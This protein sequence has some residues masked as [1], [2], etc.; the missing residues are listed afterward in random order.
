MTAGL[1][2]LRVALLALAVASC[3]SSSPLAISSRSLA[4]GE[5][6]AMALLGGSLARQSE[7]G[8]G[9]ARGDGQVL[10]VWW[11]GGWTAKTDGA[12]AALLDPSGKTIARVGDA[13][14]IGGGIGS[15]GWVHACA[16]GRSPSDLI[17]SQ[18]P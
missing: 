5:V 12:S 14:S 3:A 11:P 9:L 7:S 8:L 10:A 15:D 4:P 1:R 16:V 18:T 2:L 17:G 13:V 6:C